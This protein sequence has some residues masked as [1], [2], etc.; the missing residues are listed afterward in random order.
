LNLLFYFH[1]IYLEL[2]LDKDHPKHQGKTHALEQ[3]KNP[4]ILNNNQW[5]ILCQLQN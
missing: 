4:R 2:R 3:E 5:Y 1:E